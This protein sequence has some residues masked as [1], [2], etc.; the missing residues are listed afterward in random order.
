MTFFC[1]HKWFRLWQSRIRS[2]V[3]L[4]RALALTDPLFQRGEEKF[5]ISDSGDQRSRPH[6]LEGKGHSPGLDLG[7]R[8]PA[9]LVA[10]DGVEKK[11]D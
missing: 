11:T 10:G 7:E 2:N 3:L 6:R 5:M 8:W 9:R 1:F 4:R